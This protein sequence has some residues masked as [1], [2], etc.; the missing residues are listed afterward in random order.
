MIW[1]DGHQYWLYAAVDPATN[2]FLHVQLYY[3][4]TTALT[5]MFLAE[6]MEKHD[7]EVAVFLI[8]SAAWLKAA[9]YRRGLEQAVQT[10]PPPD[11]ALPS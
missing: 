4:L 1:I 5:E 6:L 7:V 3:A 2:R 11:H 9:H 8:D 10:H